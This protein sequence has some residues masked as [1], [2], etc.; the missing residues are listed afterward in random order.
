MNKSKYLK[1]LIEEN[2]LPDIEDYMDELFELIASKKATEEDK[3]DLEEMREMKKDFENIL[4]DINSGDM[5][6]DE[7]D[8]LISYIED[9]LKMEEDDSQ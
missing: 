4:Q 5:E 2:V 7:Y 6:E 9:M 3:S 8:E 1:K